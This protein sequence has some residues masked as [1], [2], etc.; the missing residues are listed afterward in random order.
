MQITITDR[1]SRLTEEL[2]EYARR[3]LEGLEHVWSRLESAHLIVQ[4]EGLDIAAEV[5]L[6]TT[7]GQ[8]NTRNTHP[9]LHVA[10]DGVV[11]KTEQR[12]KK[13]KDKFQ[14]QRKPR[15]PEDAGEIPQDLP[16]LIREEGFEVKTLK[17][18]EAT[19][20]M[21]ASTYSFL[22]YRDALQ[23]GLRVIFRRRDGNLGL[24]E[25]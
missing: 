13:M 4:T 25:L 11:K 8:I 18:R 22:I 19:F 24:I 15:S 16:R 9:D 14:N 17:E 2:Q 20:K 12:L 3:K 7:T 5:N 6:K 21:R 23:G 1:S 10:L